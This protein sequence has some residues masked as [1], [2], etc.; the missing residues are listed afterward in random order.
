MSQTIWI[1]LKLPVHQSGHNCNPSP[2]QHK[3]YL[4]SFLLWNTMNK[5]LR[6]LDM[7]AVFFFPSVNHYRNPFIRCKVLLVVAWL[8]ADVMQPRRRWNELTAHKPPSSLAFSVCWSRP[9]SRTGAGGM[10]IRTGKR[11]WFM[12]GR[13]DQG[14]VKPRA[15]RPAR[16]YWI[17]PLLKRSIMY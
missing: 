1:L 16:T 4:S 13:T 17:Q 10:G 6:K 12:H 14:P 11:G 8:K 3:N 7:S 9:Q 5:T 15:Q 2:Q